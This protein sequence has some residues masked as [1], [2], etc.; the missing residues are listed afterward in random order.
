MNTR[1]NWLTTATIHDEH[2]QERG[3]PPGGGVVAVLFCGRV[4][5]FKRR[6]VPD[7]EAAL[8]PAV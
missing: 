5:R 6:P 3:G 2:R 4:I 8:P 1:D 7:V